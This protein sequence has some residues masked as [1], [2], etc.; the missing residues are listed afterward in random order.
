MI[1]SWNQINSYNYELYCIS[2]HRNITNHNT[3]H[4]IYITE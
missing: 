2:H 1:K 4:W 3:W